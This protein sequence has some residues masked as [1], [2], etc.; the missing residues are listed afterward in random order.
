MQR[1]QNSGNA[2]KKKL[3]IS[4]FQ[5]LRWRWREKKLSRTYSKDLKYVFLSIEMRDWKLV[6]LK[7]RSEAE[8]EYLC[9][10]PNEVQK[11]QGISLRLL[12][13]SIWVRPNCTILAWNSFEIESVVG[14]IN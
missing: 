14:K 2:Y 9:R 6:T 8:N 7:L 3:G 13:H 5:E 12:N 10:E 4:T 1:D 11:K